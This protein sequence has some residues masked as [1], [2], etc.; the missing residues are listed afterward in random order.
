MDFKHVLGELEFSY[1]DLASLDVLLDL[2]VCKLCQFWLKGIEFLSKSLPTGS[3]VWH[4]SILDEFILIFLVFDIDTIELFLDVSFKSLES[5]E[6]FLVSINQFDGWER[7]F[8]GDIDLISHKS[9][10]LNSILHPLNIFL[11]LFVNQRVTILWDRGEMDAL[12]F[13]YRTILQTIS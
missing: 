3:I 12:G 7:V 8:H 1:F 11:G 6:D 4:D 10:C 13:F 2:F 9:S 5:I